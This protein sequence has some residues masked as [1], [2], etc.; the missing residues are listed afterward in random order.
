MRAYEV[1]LHEHS[2]AALAATRGSE[3]QRLLAR[4]DEVKAMPFRK[5]D[6]Q[7]S[8]TTGRVNEVV[9]LGDWLV[10]YWSDHAVAQI[11]VVNLERV[12]D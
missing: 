9:L 2:W 6:F 8:D 10:T 5:G 11:H 4:L 12:E 3:T 1:I 7:Q